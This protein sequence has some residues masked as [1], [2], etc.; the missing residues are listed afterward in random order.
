MKMTRAGRRASST[1]Y[2]ETSIP[3]GMTR[4]RH[5]PRTA[6]AATLLTAVAT[7]SRAAQRRNTG[8]A[9]R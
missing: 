7:A 9:H 5:S 6:A 4:G 3:L 1:S 8:R 2:E